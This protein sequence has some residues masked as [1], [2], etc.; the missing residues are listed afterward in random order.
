MPKTRTLRLRLAA[1]MLAAIALVV[2]L[3]GSVIGYSPSAAAAYAD[4]WWN[5][6]NPAWFTVSSDCTNFVSQST[7]SGGMP[8]SYAPNNPWYAYRDYVGWH[9]S[10]SWTTVQYNHGY[11]PLA[12]HGTVVNTYL[13]VKTAPTIGVQGDLVYYAWN[14]DQ[15]F[16]HDSHEAIITVTS[17]RAT[18]TSD[19]GALVDAH[20]NP[21]F[22]EYWTLYQWNINWPTT[23]YQV[24]HIY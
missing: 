8:M 2:A 4:Q 19:V 11:F 6:Y 21:R 20:S 5:S 15:T 12:G 24:M 7:Y 16:S 10:Q 14:N 3:P 22:H 1:R 23:Y 18:S 9:W 17:G 13:G